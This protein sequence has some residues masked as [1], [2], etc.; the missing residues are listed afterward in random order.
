MAPFGK[1]KNEQWDKE[2]MQRVANIVPT[3]KVLFIFSL[4]LD[5]EYGVI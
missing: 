3:L 1:L 5:H 4:S 2:E